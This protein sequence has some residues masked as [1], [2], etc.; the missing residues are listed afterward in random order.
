VEIPQQVF[1]AD[2]Y[3]IYYRFLETDDEYFDYAPARIPPQGRWRI[4]GVA[5]PEQILR[6]VYNQNAERVL[7]MKLVGA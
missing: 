4:Y 1:G 2:L 7:G 3:H 6:K 5:L